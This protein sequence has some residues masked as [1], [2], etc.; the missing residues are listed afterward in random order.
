VTVWPRK[1]W[2]PPIN[3]RASTAQ[4]TR[5]ETRDASRRCLVSRVSCLV[6]LPVLRRCGKVMRLLARGASRPRSIG[7]CDR[8]RQ[9]SL[10]GETAA[11]RAG[12]EDYSS[13]WRAGLEGFGGL[14]QRPA[15]AQVPR[16]LGPRGFRDRPPPPF[17]ARLAAKAPVEIDAQ[18]AQ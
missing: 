6:S 3:A 2:Q 12:P 8:G 15:P 18:E 13:L 16:H 10:G 4:D 17:P 11:A 1:V 5:L 7:R 9:P 14:R